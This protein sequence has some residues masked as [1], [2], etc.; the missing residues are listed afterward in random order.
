MA[1]EAVR[2]RRRVAVPYCASNM[3]SS[4]ARR[5]AAPLRRRDGERRWRH[6]VKP[7]S[8]AWARSTEQCE[9]EEMR[10]RRRRC[11]PRAVPRPF[12]AKEEREERETD[13]WAQDRGGPPIRETEGAAGL[14][15][16]WGPPASGRERARA[17]VARETERGGR[18]AQMSWRQGATPLTVHLTKGGCYCYSPFWRFQGP[19]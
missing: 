14:A 2:L 11:T 5:V 1:S 7:T 17:E 16:G 6:G 19:K 9:A 10:G 3:R 13:R 8:S 12:R 4:R 18:G 15:D